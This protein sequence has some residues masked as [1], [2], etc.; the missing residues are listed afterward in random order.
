MVTLNLTDD[1]AVTL[2]DQLLT[3]MDF[4]PEGERL[5]ELESMAEKV[6]RQL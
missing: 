4:Q 5:D 6:R 2:Y 1:E 3:D